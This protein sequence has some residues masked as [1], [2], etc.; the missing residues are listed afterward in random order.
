MLRLYL[1]YTFQQFSDKFL[2]EPTAMQLEKANKPLS[3]YMT[4]FV[5]MHPYSVI[6]WQRAFQSCSLPV[7]TSLP[8]TQAASQ[9]SDK[10]STRLLCERTLINHQLN[11][12]IYCVISR[13]LVNTSQILLTAVT[14]FLT[15]HIPVRYHDHDP[16][17]ILY[18]SN[19]CKGGKII[20][21]NK[22]EKNQQ[23]ACSFIEL[24]SSQD[25]G[26][27]S[28]NR[29]A[30]NEKPAGYNITLCHFHL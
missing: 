1:I 18:N 10:N 24:T 16:S 28:N 11:Q 29:S 4:T 6:Y 22:R 12:T 25:S 15:P 27:Y 23:I 9:T 5:Q 19:P 2:I 20:L 21:H 14:A 26:F 8:I 7:L 3:A 13:Q 30:A 17:A